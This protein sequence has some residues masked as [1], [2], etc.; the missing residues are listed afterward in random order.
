MGSVGFT[1]SVPVEVILAAG[2]RPVDLNNV[3]ITAPRPQ[4]LV[5]EAEAA[6]YPRTV[7]GW[8][9][10]L[11]AVAARIPDLEAVVAVMQGD[12]SNTQ[13]LLETLVMRGM[14][15]VPFAYPFDRDAGLLALQMEK[16]MR[17]LGTDWAGVREVQRRLR[18]V[19]RLV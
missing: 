15:T 6:G 9:K 3:F 4:D 14:H 13:A 7:C 19:R 16:F 18:E 2:K 11:Y 1:T 5:E 8:I 10:G 17:L 12:C